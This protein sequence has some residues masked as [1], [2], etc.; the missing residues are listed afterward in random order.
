[1]KPTHMQI[2][3]LLADV[4]FPASR[5]GLVS[6]ARSHR[7]PTEVVEAIAVLPDRS[8]RDPNEVGQAF[9][10]HQHRAAESRG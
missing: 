8:Y 5:D 10:D 9:A 2:Q 7:A 1:M 3:K 4:R 6:Y